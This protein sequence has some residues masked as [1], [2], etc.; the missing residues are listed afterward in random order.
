MEILTEFEP[1]ALGEV[2]SL[3]ARHYARHWGFGTVFECKV[4]RE[5]ADFAARRAADDLVL[6]ARDE[7]GIAASLI[8]DAGD[9][10]S[11]P[12]GAHLRWFIV[13]GRARGSGLGRRL[14]ARAVARAEAVSG[15]RAWLTTFAGLAPARHLYEA[16]GFVLAREEE[17]AAWGTR[18]IEQE[19]RRPADPPA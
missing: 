8:L 4:A 13:A 18:V 2:V 1:G 3:H 16:H 14:L 5:M 17:G 11:G 7:A 19:F 10:A 6:L 15:G 12:R 9:P